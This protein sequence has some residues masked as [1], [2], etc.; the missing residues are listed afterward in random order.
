ML[1]PL[2]RVEAARGAREYLPSLDGPRE[3]VRRT[4]VLSV[5]GQ[6]QRWRPKAAVWFTSLFFGRV[7]A[8]AKDIR[9]AP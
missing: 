3:R 8:G 1:D 9:E 6:R 4:L 2:E 5:K 7:R